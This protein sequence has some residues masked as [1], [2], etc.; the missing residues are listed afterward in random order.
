MQIAG[1]L[2]KQSG[3]LPTRGS[4]SYRIVMA[5][6]YQQG[7]DLADGGDGTADTASTDCEKVLNLP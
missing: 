6:F 3:M 4:D 7:L 5:L 1:V 2:T